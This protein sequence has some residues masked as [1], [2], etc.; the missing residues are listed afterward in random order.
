MNIDF[1]PQ[2]SLV[3]F[4]AEK[5]MIFFSCSENIKEKYRLKTVLMADFL[6]KAH[7][8]EYFIPHNEIQ[9]FDPH[10]NLLRLLLNLSCIHF[11]H[12]RGY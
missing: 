7:S 11:F 3:I 10:R 6:T 9:T 4:N 1:F 5:H 8:L 2:V 12:I